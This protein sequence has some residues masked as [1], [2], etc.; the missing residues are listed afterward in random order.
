MIFD[1][2]E[3]DANSVFFPLPEHTRIPRT[4]QGS[5]VKE[6]Q[7]PARGV[8]SG[9]RVSLGSEMLVHVH[10]ARWAFGGDGGGV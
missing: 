7:R 4:Q 10:V 9:E 6:F 8:I 2:E 1:I 5:G 3:D